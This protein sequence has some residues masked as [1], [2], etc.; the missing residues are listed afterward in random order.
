MSRVARGARA[1]PH[2]AT[3]MASAMEAFQGMQRKLQEESR[4]YESLAQ[5]A[6]TKT[7]PPRVVIT[8]SI[9]LGQ[10]N[11]RRSSETVAKT[12]EGRRARAV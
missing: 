8:I 9:D 2:G 4:T 1:P 7:R 11:E 3:T 12:D 10:R 6:S 5:G